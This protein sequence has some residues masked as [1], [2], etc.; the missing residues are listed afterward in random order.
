METCN[1]ALYTRRFFLF[2]KMLKSRFLA[3]LQSFIIG[4]ILPNLDSFGQ[5]F[6]AL[7]EVDSMPQLGLKS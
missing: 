4:Q 5:I 6:A 3:K 7:T 1:N 2:G